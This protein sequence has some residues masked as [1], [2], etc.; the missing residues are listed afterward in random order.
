MV[1][2]RLETLIAEGADMALRLAR[3][4]ARF[5]R[6]ARPEGWLVSSLSL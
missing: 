2:N 5:L 4:Q 3:W 6:P 1:S